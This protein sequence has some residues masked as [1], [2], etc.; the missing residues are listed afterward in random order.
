[1]KKRDKY[2][3]E[4]RRARPLVLARDDNRCVKCGASMAL[5]VHHIE[6]YKHNEEK[7]LVTLCYLCHAIAPMGKTLFDQW[8]LIGESGADV[9]KRRLCGRDIPRMNNRQIIEFCAVLTEFCGDALKQRMIWARNAMREAGVLE[10]G[11]KPYGNKHGESRIIEKMKELRREGKT[12]Q[13]VADGLTEAGLLSRYGKEWRAATVH[14]ILV[15]QNIQRGPK[16][17]ESK[18]L[19]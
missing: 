16:L 15:R 1:M 19:F 13:E 9:L 10:E 18:Y 2:T 11:R 17:D 4:F 7:D 5:E 3:L 8:L 14:K 6:G 12:F